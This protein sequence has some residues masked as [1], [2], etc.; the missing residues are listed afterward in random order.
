[1]EQISLH[2]YNGAYPYGQPP[3]QGMMPGM[4]PWGMGWGM[5][6]AMSQY[7]GYGGQ[8]DPQAQMMAQQAAQMVC[9]T[10]LDLKRDRTLIRP[11]LRFRSCPAGLSAGD[12]VVLADG[13]ADGLT[14]G[15]APGQPGHDAVAL[16]G[17]A[18]PGSDA[19]L[20][21]HVAPCRAAH[22]SEPLPPGPAVRGLAGRL[23]LQRRRRTRV[24]GRPA[25]RFA[26][27]P[28]AAAAA[29]EPVIDASV[30]LKGQPDRP[31]APSRQPLISRSRLAL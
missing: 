6:P 26:Q 23:R 19:L 22:E 20:G 16:N 25:A 17:L 15:L 24:T 27:R 10:F 21:R 11:I 4:M 14:A 1:M 18:R 7:G 29:A 28:A 30:E 3:P 31:V 2:G 9:P 5:P 13:V 8:M 12:D